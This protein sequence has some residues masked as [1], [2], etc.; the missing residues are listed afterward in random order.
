MIRKVIVPQVDT[1]IQEVTITTWYKKEGQ[2]VRKGEPLAEMTTDKATFDFES[3]AAG[4]LRRIVAGRR[5]TVP[6]GYVIAL[7]G[8]PDDA[9]PDVD[10][11]NRALLQE[12]KALSLETSNKKAGQRAEVSV[13]VRATPAAR[14]L[15]RE[16]SLDLAAIQAS[17]QAPVVTEETIKAFLARK[18]R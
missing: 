12:H 18:T 2:A 17:T 5:S 1:N 16:Q 10:P 13:V 7:L 6:I 9:L 8:A 14:R 4:I 11:S 3:P 15:A